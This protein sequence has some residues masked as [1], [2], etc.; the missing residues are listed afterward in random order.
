MPKSRQPEAKGMLH[1]IYEA[2]TQKEAEK[3][4]DRFI[5]V[6]EAKHPK[7]AECPAKDRALMLAFYDF[8]AVHW[9]HIRS[10]NPIESTFATVRLRTKHTRGCAS[11]NPTVSMTFKLLVDAKK[12]WRKLNG[13]KLMAD[14][15]DIIVKFVDGIRKAA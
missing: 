2:E 11:A 12:G 3:A 10:T 7:A 13:H 1:E 9:R 4:F 5:E 15:I 8:P 6:F 14:V